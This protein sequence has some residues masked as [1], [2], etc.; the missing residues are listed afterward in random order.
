M[1][2]A[3]HKKVIFSLTA[4]AVMSLGGVTA[5]A[6]TSG[7]TPALT[8][9]SNVDVSKIE[10]RMGEAKVAGKIDPKILESM[11]DAKTA[12]GQGP[13]L[14]LTQAPDGTYNLENQSEIKPGELKAAGKI[15]SRVLEGMKDAK[16]AP[17]TVK[18]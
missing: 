12:P 2:Y 3:K 8:P 17:G 15:D 10:G 9:V 7:I 18:R 4:A 1:S 6:A 11:K 14:T 13:A 5:F 16:T